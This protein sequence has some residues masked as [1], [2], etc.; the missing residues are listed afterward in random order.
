MKV[1]V[2]YD[3]SEI[4]EFQSDADKGH[5]YL[6]LIFVPEKMSLLERAAKGR[7][8]E[9]SM[10]FYPQRD[11]DGTIDQEF[12][13]AIIEAFNNKEIDKEPVYVDRVS[14]EI[15][16]VV[17]TYQTDSR[18]G[19]YSKGDVIMEGN[20]ARV[21]T[22]IQLTCLMKIVKGEEVPIMSKNEL[23]TRA[24]AIRAYRIDEGQWYDAEEYLANANDETEEEETPDVIDDE[25]E[26]KQ[27]SQKHQPNKPVRR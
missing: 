15:A 2:D 25:P 13:D 14:V 19:N 16:P 24:N 11:N 8:S 18:R 7:S 27:Q 12:E 1:K 17:M 22:S 23:K 6:R 26:P 9:Y 20:N 21:Y 10:N 4:V 5:N 3:R